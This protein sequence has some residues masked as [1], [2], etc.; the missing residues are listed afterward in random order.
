MAGAARAIGNASAIAPKFSV[1][2]NALS[3]GMSST[4]KGF[5]TFGSSSSGPMANMTCSWLNAIVAVATTR[6]TVHRRRREG[7]RPS[8][9]NNGTYT[10]TRATPTTKDQL[11]NQAIKLVS[12]SV[13]AWSVTLAPT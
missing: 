3:I 1:S 9:K 4:P 7:R 5:R 8:G 13:P 12:G 11:S 6:N 2:S 10:P